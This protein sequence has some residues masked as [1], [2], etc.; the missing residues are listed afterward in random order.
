MSTSGI[1]MAAGTAEAHLPLIE[2]EW[3][4]QRLDMHDRTEDWTGVTSSIERRKLQNRL[5]QRARSKLIYDL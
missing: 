3:S 2:F 4:S 5:N 1:E